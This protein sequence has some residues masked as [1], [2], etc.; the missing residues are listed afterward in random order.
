VKQTPR[1]P[2]ILLPE[3]SDQNSTIDVL[4]ATLEGEA[5]AE[6]LGHLKTEVFARETTSSTYL[7][8]GLAIP[9]GRIPGLNHVLL[10]VGV[11]APGILWP[12]AGQDAHLI[13]LLGVPSSMV[14][15]YLVLMQRLLR[16]YK[17]APAIRPDHF[18]EDIQQV[19][20]AILTLL[21]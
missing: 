4:L 2:I 12:E 14:A 16:W 18:E 11:S 6:V 7:D 10:A 21:A 20:S 3:S 5:S 1:I 19:R 9:H 8:N 15:G 13:I 17:D